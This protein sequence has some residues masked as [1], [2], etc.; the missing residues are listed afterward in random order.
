MVKLFK[1]HKYSGLTAG[2][3][4]LIL[5][6]TGFF[7]DHKNWSFM[8]D[9][10][11]ENLPKS[12]YKHEKRLIEAYWIDPEDAQHIVVGSRRGVFEKTDEGFVKT[13]D[14]QCLGLRS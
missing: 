12:V 7:L 8:Y 6:F 4:L 9:I 2:I 11:F 14:R 13:L 3:L 10:S 1:V 5:S